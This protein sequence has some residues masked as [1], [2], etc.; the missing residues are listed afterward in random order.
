MMA[1]PHMLAGAAI[2]V[3]LDRRPW[4]ALPAA[5]ASHFV[6]DAIPHL[7]SHALYGVAQG[8]PTGPEAGIAIAD[9]ALAWVVIALLTRSRPWRAMAFAG[10]FC[11]ILIDLVYTI[12]PW[13]PWF[14]TWR[15]TA[16]LDDFHHGIQ[17][18]LTP[19]QWLIGFGTQAVVIG[20][21]VWLLTRHRPD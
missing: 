15:G 20:V 2:G 11:G 19:D 4:L 7:D 17:P 6:L 18:H 21:T 3:V 13:G 10:A 16:W 14:S 1:T 8:G 12:P 9:F 5:F